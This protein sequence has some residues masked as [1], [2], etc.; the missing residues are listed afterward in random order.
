MQALGSVSEAP[1]AAVRVW[2]RRRKPCS[3]SCTA[4]GAGSALE[5]GA[6][7]WR[8]EEPRGR[9]EDVASVGACM[10]IGEHRA[11][12]IVWSTGFG[13][14]GRVESSH[15]SHRAQLSG[16]IK[17]QERRKQTRAAPTW[18]RCQLGDPRDPPGERSQAR[19]TFAAR[20]S[21][22]GTGAGPL[23]GGNWNAQSFGNP[24]GS[25]SANLSTLAGGQAGTKSHSLLLIPSLVPTGLGWPPALRDL[26]V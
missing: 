24:S 22:L 25:Y 15:S 12:S 26:S 19:L 10:R 13:G 21:G 20:R 16:K 1:N 14:S 17:G 4:G 6:E 5:R 9:T 7:L 8:G 18:L 11:L 2:L 23:D 3:G